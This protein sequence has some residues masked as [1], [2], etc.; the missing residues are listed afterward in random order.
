MGKGLDIW[1]SAVLNEYL[2]LQFA[3]PNFLQLQNYNLYECE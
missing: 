3:H 1:T 2:H